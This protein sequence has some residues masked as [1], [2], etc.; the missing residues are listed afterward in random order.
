M[1]WT[2]GW[3]FWPTQKIPAFIAK[4]GRVAPLFNWVRLALQTQPVSQAP[5]GL[6]QFHL[7]GEDFLAHRFPLLEVN[8]A[9][10]APLYLGLLG[11]AAFAGSGCHG[12]VARKVE[13]TVLA[14]EGEVRA[15][16]GGS[17]RI[18]SVNST[19]GRNQTL[20]TGA[21]GSV[22]LLLLPGALLH[23]GPDSALRI[24]EIVL[25]KDGNALEDAME[26][27]VRLQLL[28][29]EAD[30][31]IQ[32]ESAAN[33][34]T[35]TT[36]HGRLLV[37]APATARLQVRPA[38]TRIDVAR[39]QVHFAS[40]DTNPP[41]SV[42]AGFSQSWPGEGDAIAAVEDAVSQ[43]QIEDLLR[44]EQEMLRLQRARRFQ[45]RPW[46]DL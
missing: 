39:G 46:R 16:N 24:E 21:D 20:R 2:A 36:P 43:Q 33:Q 31:V 34:F 13:A 3:E 29:G 25:T 4:L 12:N 28:A 27:T 6:G 30:L 19:L 32:F 1:I 37:T 22:S 42:V 17:T 26:R 9:F 44:V 45:P 14:A 38:Q 23:L 40:G 41:S 7:S 10:S 11:V 35:V 5:P 8:P 15:G 18:L